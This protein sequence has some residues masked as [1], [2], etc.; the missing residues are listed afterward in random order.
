MTKVFLTMEKKM[1]T[2]FSDNIGE[3]IAL[4]LIFLIKIFLLQYLWN[5]YISENILPYRNINLFE[6]FIISLF[7][8]LLTWNGEKK[9]E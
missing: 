1:N 2:K 7:I 5:T 9:S 3:V 4:L 8:Q 6:T